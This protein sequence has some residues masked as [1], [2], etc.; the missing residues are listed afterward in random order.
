M[1]KLILLL[2]FSFLVV[3]DSSGITREDAIKELQR[4][5]EVKEQLSKMNVS[6][7]ADY[8]CAINIFFTL[9]DQGTLTETKL[10]SLYLGRSFTVERVSGE[11]SGLSIALNKNDYGSPEVLDRGSAVQAFKVLTVYKPYITITY[12][13]IQEFI[14]KK[15]KPFFMVDGSTILSGSCQHL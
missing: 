7:D 12:L 9:N 13:Y 3:A 2:V 4:R 10:G 14:S 15:E 11:T 8:R 1:G 5:M 6:L